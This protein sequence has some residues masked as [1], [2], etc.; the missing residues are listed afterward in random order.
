MKPLLAFILGCAL[1]YALTH[2]P[3][4]VAQEKPLLIEYRVD[5]C[6]ADD[7]GVKRLTVKDVKEILE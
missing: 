3:R 4:A 5:V 2:E 1:T 7:I 6:A